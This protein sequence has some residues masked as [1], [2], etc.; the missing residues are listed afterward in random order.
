[1]RKILMGLWVLM[2]MLNVAT[3]QR[4]RTTAVFD[5]DTST[6]PKAGWYGVGVR[7]GK[8]YV[9]KPTGTTERL[10]AANTHVGSSG[11]FLYSNGTVNYFKTPVKAD[12][13]LGSVNNTSDLSKPIST[14]TQTALNGKFATP[15]GLTTNFL[16]KW[17]GSGFVNTELYSEPN[18]FTS[19]ASNFT[20]TGVFPIIYL[21]GTQASANQIQLRNYIGGVSNA[22]FEIY[23]FT[24]SASR[25]V[26]NSVG[27]IGIGTGTPLRRLDIKNSAGN[28]QTMTLANSDFVNGTTGTSL[29]F[30][31]GAVSGNT[32]YNIQSLIGGETGAGNLSLQPV[33][34]NVGI[35]TASPTSK[36]QVVGLP[37]Y[38]DNAAATSG[39]LTAGAFYRTSIGVLMVVY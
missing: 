6:R 14:A 13:G 23:D 1:M 12:V 32:S 11:Q 2:G 18:Y 37:T 17:N 7:S 29:Q 22:G 26:I 36:L 19:L 28:S 27:N 21:S 20:I 30:S 16:P 39:G 15:T 4:V 24:N 8:V 31:T 10:V 33:G 3:A 5:A 34:G 9:V 38:A 35:G 25:M